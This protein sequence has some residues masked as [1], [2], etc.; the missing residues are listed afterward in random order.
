MHMSKWLLT[1]CLAASFAGPALAAQPYVGTDRIAL[2]VLLPPPPEAG[3][4]EDAA[5]MQAVLDA[6]SHA[7]AARKRQA[8]ADDNESA[9]YTFANVLGAGFREADL[10]RVAAL[11]ARLAADEEGV[12]GAAK[13]DFGRVRPWLANPAVEPGPKPEKSASYPSGH[14]TRV[15]LDAIV[16]SAMVPEMRRA[17]WARAE[18]YAQSR[19]IAGRHF[20]TDL[21]AGWRAGTA[22]AALIMAQPPFRADLAA[23]KAELR[24]VLGLEATR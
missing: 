16:L 3:S 14:T 18:D 17:I 24:A 7:G 12:V 22:L 11:F 4:A 13:R 15:T 19:V 2:G 21:Q 1:T 9:F 10:P 5:D 6:Q 8:Y 23:A 20:P